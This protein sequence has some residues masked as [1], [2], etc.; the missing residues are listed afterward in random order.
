MVA[1]TAVNLIGKCSVGKLNV[2]CHVNNLHLFS[3]PYSSK[4]T[5][6]DYF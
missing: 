1:Q 2:T 6:N 3:K 4:S 5:T